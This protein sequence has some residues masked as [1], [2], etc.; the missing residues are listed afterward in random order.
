MRP[1]GRIA[2][3]QDG[4]TDS[5]RRE[6]P[7]RA[8]HPAGTFGYT[9]AAFDMRILQLAL[10]FYFQKGSDQLSAFSFQLRLSLTADK[11]N[12]FE[13]MRRDWTLQSGTRRLEAVRRGRAENVLPRSL[14]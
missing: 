3:A 2:G 6:M 7:A 10:K 11:Q 5:S 1:S 4:G 9:H 14:F 13:I 12:W 8:P